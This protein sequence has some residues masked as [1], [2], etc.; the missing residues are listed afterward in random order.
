MKDVQQGR[1]TMIIGK[2]SHV[3]LLSGLYLSLHAMAR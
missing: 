2:G 3:V 1:S